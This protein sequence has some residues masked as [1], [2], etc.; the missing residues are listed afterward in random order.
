ME[1][2]VAVGQHGVGGLEVPCYYVGADSGLF[3]QAYEQ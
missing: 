1:L 2:V 3:C